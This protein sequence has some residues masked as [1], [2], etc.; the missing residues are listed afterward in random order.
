MREY[1][2]W[3]ADSGAAMSSINQ[4]L[5][6]LRR[7]FRNAAEAGFVEREK[8]EDAAQVENARALGVRAGHWL[9][10][11]QAKALLL[12]PDEKTGKGKRDR[13]ILAVLIG[14]GLQ[15]EELVLLN[16]EDIQLREER[17]VIPDLV[18]KGGRVR[19]VPIPAWVK[20]RL[21]LWTTSGAI[22]EK[23]IFRALRKHGAV[24]SESLSV[25]AIWRLVPEHAQ[26][27]GI[28]HLTPHDLRRTCAK[29]CRKIGG[30][31]EQ[32]QFLLRHSSIQTTEKYLGGK[33]DVG[34][35]VNDRLFKRTTL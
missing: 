8:A 29:L 15:R 2:T 21:D 33:Q 1:R 19:L 7:M 31:L 34:R 10:A 22:R 17:W 12:A 20:E 27:A 25:S 30:N 28:Q 9:T 5:S 35:A 6:A 14:C 32:I 23:R 3:L 11:D 4:E 24:S 13:A 26:A 18:G 16:V